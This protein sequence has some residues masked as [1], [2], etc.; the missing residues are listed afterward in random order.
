MEDKHG[1]FPSTTSLAYEILGRKY[2]A[3]RVGER[4]SLYSIFLPFKQAMFPQV[5]FITRN[6]C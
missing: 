3:L 1:S 2:C 6:P 5:N 4:E